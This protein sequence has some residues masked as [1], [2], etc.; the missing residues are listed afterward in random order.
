M[1]VAAFGRSLESGAPW[2]GLNNFTPRHLR[3]LPWWLGRRDT[4][5]LA[6]FVERA[7]EV[8]ARGVAS[9]VMTLRVRLLGAMATA[10]LALAR[11]DSA[12]ALR[13][14]E[15]IQDTLCLSDEFA[16]NCFHLNLTRARLLEAKGELRRAGD[17]LELWRWDVGKDPVFV[18]ATLDL[19]RIAERLGEREQ[20]TERYRFVTEVWRQADPELEP[21]V[22]EA[23]EALERLA[24]TQ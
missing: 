1:A 20:A 21:Y 17:L 13:R 9:P 15:A 18:L 3:G 5:S 19:G 12:T 6:R 4:L 22:T 24:R 14:L 10:Y 11:G 8:A 7:N 23:R 16:N 2:G